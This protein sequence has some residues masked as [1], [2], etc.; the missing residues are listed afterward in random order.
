[1]AVVIECTTVVI[2][3]ASLERRFPG[4]LAGFAQRLPNNTYRGDGKLAAVSFMDPRDARMFVAALAKHGLS[5][6]WSG[7][8]EDVAVV[9]QSQ[10]FLAPCD[11]LEVDLRQFTGQDGTPFA[12]TVAWAD[13]ELTTLA[14]PPGWHP[15]RAEQVTTEE[16][17]R[18]YEVV[19]IDRDQASGGSVTA[20]RHRQTGKTLYI[21]RP[22]PPGYQEL[23]ERYSAL[24][25][26][27]GR[28]L[29]MPDLPQRSAEAAV[30]YE[31]A[32]ALI[33]HAD[34]VPP[35]FLLQ[36]I[37]AR[38]AN[39]WDNAERVFREMTERWP[40]NREAWLELTGALGRLGR[41]GEAEAAARRALDIDEASVAARVNLASTLLYQD[42]PAEA[43]PEIERA[44]ALDPS[45]TMVR[46]VRAQIHRALDQDSA[47]REAGV[48]WYK[49][50][51]R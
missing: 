38:L 14:V 27:C 8:S 26:E 5:D 36:G 16:L 17:E 34:P 41:L 43:L 31:Q 24:A 22:A 9:D 20:Y 10:G 18:N 1:M 15:R 32:T 12:A 35:L 3:S 33:E 11:W 45:N 40:D 39:Q 6:P 29:G 51:F 25:D 4:G 46:A 48:P 42:R 23:Q 7:R 37:A 21:G 44:F 47:G 28:L 49:R 50:W 30:L 13:G 19:R 2:V